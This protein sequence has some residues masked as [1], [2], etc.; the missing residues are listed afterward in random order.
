MEQAT[1]RNTPGGPA[2]DFVDKLER[3]RGDGYRVIERAWQGGNGK[4]QVSGDDPAGATGE[5]WTLPWGGE[6][7][8]GSS[9][10]ASGAAGELAGLGVGRCDRAG[11]VIP[12]RDSSA[13]I[14]SRVA[15]SR[16]P[17]ASLCRTP[18][19]KRRASQR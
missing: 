9:G 8:M 12:S 1:V 15:G 3:L 17:S 7:V 4:I 18:V 6:G 19:T 2:S 16:S 11:Q 14:S 10:A 13:F 5:A